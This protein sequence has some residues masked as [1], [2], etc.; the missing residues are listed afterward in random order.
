MKVVA[1]FGCYLVVV[2]FA[3]ARADIYRWDNRQLIPGTEGITPGP[4]VVLDHH[5]LAFAALS[6]LDLTGARFDFSNLSNAQFLGSTLTNAKLT[7]AVVTGASFWAA[8]S[9]GFTQAQLASTASNQTK[10]LQGIDLESNNLTGWDF[11]GQNLTD[12]NFDYSTL[13]NADLTGAVVTGASFGDTTSRGFTRAQLASTASYQTKNLRGI[14]LSN[15]LTGWDFSGQDLTNANLGL[16]TLIDA[17]LTGAMVTRAWFNG[18][19]SRGFTQAQLASTASYQT[20]N[21][22]GIVLVTNDLTGWDF[23]G[24]DL[25]NANLDSSTLTNANLAGANLTNAS[26]GSS[27][28]TNADLTG[29]DTRGVQY[30][31]LTE[32]TSRNT[33]LPNGAI[34]GLNLAAGEQLVVR[35]DDGGSYP[36]SQYWVT[37]RLPIPINIQDRLMMS[38]GGILQLL[39]DADAWDSTI[40]FQPGIQV[41]IGGNL[42]LSFAPDV[43]PVSQIGRTFHIFDWTG[44]EP[45]GTFTVSSPHRWDVSQLYTT[46]DVTL[47]PEPATVLLV[48]CALVAVMVPRIRRRR[49]DNAETL[50]DL[51]GSALGH[52]TETIMRSARLMLVLWSW[53]SCSATYG[54][55]QVLNRT[56]QHDGETR[57]YTL[58]VPPAYTGDEAWPLVVNLHFLSGSASGQI[59]RSGM[60]S[61]ANDGHFLVAYPNALVNP[62]TGLSQWNEGSMFPN[63]PDDVGFVGALIDRLEDDYHINPSKVYAAGMSLGGMMTY[64]L[65]SQLSHRLAAIASVGGTDPANPTAPRP[66]PVLHMHGS[67]DPIVPFQ[68]GFANVPPPLNS[69]RLPAVAD[70]IDGWRDSNNCVDEPSI[71]QLPNLNTQDGSTVEMI[72]Y[73][74]CDCYLTSSGDERPAEV[75]YYRIA[76]GG[77]TWPS[78]EAHAP[79]FGTVNRDINASEEI[80][81]FFSRHELPA[82]M[83]E[84][85]PGDYNQN[86]EVDAAD[87]VVWRNGVGTTYDQ[88]DYVVWRANFGQ[89]AGSG[90]ALPSAEPLSAA[91]PESASVLLVILG[92]VVLFC[93]RGGTASRVPSTRQFGF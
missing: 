29:A 77:H 49:A 59:T 87:Y 90:A 70:V 32:A 34:A 60:N 46:G 1:P 72:G 12:A 65:G 39:F 28:L 45:T 47:V 22:Q 48:A 3:T 88:G 33:I 5:E 35:D 41:T 61:V 23:S 58:Y 78:G 25:T 44:V 91:V 57:S 10:N 84:P 83:P 62:Q 73:Q 40:S 50:R 11:R 21:L 18:T 16:S 24:Q 8:T 55:G 31:D 42:E 4:A 17:N 66:L 86:G 9:R 51:P 63:G 81:N 85:V 19:T 13:T 80:W 27:T 53:V 79:F 14:R 36:P 7:G 37:P 74:E 26:L 69:F 43:D 75:L 89:T 20:K 92:T 54:Q 2:L 68:G 6:E 30:L 93:R 67:E 15:N 52:N 71:T 82:V 76:G 38:D 64:Y 56:L